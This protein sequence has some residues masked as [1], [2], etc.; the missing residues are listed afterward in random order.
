MW[1][2]QIFSIA[3]EIKQCSRSSFKSWQILGSVYLTF[4]TYVHLDRYAAEESSRIET[5]CCWMTYENKEI[6]IWIYVQPQIL[7]VKHIL[8]LEAI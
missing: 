2:F 5:L 8:N 6:W 3:T 7:Q 1:K 4:N